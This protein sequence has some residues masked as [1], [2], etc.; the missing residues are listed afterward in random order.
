MATCRVSV[1][2]YLSLLW[3]EVEVGGWVAGTSQEST[4]WIRVGRPGWTGTDEPMG[5]T[6]G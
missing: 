6:V 5:M 2:S 4:A 1:Q 3:G